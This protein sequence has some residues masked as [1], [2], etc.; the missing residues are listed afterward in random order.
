MVDRGQAG[1]LR[2]YGVKTHLIQ[3]F[4]DVEEFMRWLGNRR[5]RLGCDTE[6]EGLHP[7]QDRIRLIQFGDLHDGWAIPWD[8]YR[9][10]VREVFAKY[11]GR[12]VFHN[13]KYDIRMIHHWSDIRV[14]WDRVDD[15]M[16]M[17]HLVNPLRPKGLKPLAAMYVDPEAVAS[18]VQ[19]HDAMNR[20][21]WNWK[22]VPLDFPWYW[23]YAALDPV[24]TCHIWNEMHEEV[25]RSYSK[26]YE[27]EMGAT[28]ELAQMEANG[29]RVNL[30][31][32][33][34]Q[35]DR[36]KGF[37][38]QGR[39]WLNDTCGITGIS[40]PQLIS[41]FREQGVQLLDKKTN[42][43]FQA[44]DKEVLEAID[45]PVAKMVLKIKRAEKLAEPYFRHFLDSADENDRVHPNVW[46]MGARTGRSSI[47]DPA[48]QTLPKRD[49][50]VRTAFIPEDGNALV[51]VDYHQVEARLMAYFSGDEGLRHA[52]DSG[53]FFCNL[54]SGA[55]GKKVEKHD[56][57][58]KLIKTFMYG[59]MYGAGIATLSKNAGIPEEHMRD[60]S[61]KMAKQ[62]PGIHKFQERLARIGEER[63]RTEG[64]AYVRTPTGR[65]LVADPDKIYTLTNYLIQ[66]HAAELL[67]M[68]M[69]RVHTLCDERFGAGTVHLLIPIHDE[70]VSECPVEIAQQVSDTIEEA[71]AY[72]SYTPA[73][74]AD[75][76][77]NAENWGKL[78]EE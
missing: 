31:Y 50:L 5:D 75:G 45:H 25:E 56:L 29:M 60:V 74:T 28:R 53:D 17:A 70:I 26:P 59:T 22:T 57:E 46:S 27:I 62:Y 12:Y 54:A 66:G 4:E 23:I 10:V 13:S 7:E 6:C 69:V 61:D 64:I 42:A 43:G 8:D 58:R 41:Y 40:A 1:W 30:D 78:T 24:L 33:Q 2:Q 71:M 19:L 72:P 39:A 21:R 55:Y 76:A 65:R 63:L 36:L 47:T 73:L 38:N 15:T 49:T 3:S 11:T 14:P 35:Y 77:W 48:L 20:E 16:T 32:C 68:A 18:Q 52:F 44:M 34:E 9:G 51:S 37:A 67:K